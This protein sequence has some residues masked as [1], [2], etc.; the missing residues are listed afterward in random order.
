MANI[1]TT[2][3]L[4][5]IRARAPEWLAAMERGKAAAP[6]CGAKKKSGQPCRRVPL[7]GAKHCFNHFHGPERDALDARRVAAAQRL[8]AR[9]TNARFRADAARTIKTVLR[10]QFQRLWQKDATI[11][12][13]TLEL[14]ARDEARV[15][16]WLLRGFNIDL[17]RTMHSTGDLLSPRCIDRLRWAAAL[18]L[19]GRITP[20]FARN[21]VAAAM[22]DDLK[23]WI[24]FH[25]EPP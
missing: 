6:R 9:T 20:E 4:D 10:R 8:L 1:V 17:D 21:R 3:G 15:L 25:A 5:R 14:A 19:T 22:R 13:S 23:F 18:S 24:Q 11:P 12:G 16:S 2:F 7:R